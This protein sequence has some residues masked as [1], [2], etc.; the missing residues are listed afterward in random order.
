MAT[1]C[2]FTNTTLVSAYRGAGR[3]EGNYYMER[4]I[5]Y[6]AARN[7]ASTGSS[8]AARNQIKP[9]RDS[10]SRPPPA[11]TYD[12]GDFP[13]VFKQAVELAD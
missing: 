1:K 11:R 12:S 5:D 4:L 10:A 7:W 2:V 8:C 6:A 9:K 3:P 13:A